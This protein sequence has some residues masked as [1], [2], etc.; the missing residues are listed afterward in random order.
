MVEVKKS[1][2]DGGYTEVILPEGFDVKNTKV[3]VKGAYNL[4]SAK[5]NAGDMAC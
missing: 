4:I 1:I 3:V 5:K 2:S